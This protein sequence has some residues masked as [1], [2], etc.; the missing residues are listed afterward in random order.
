M[1][2]TKESH[3]FVIEFKYSPAVV[4]EVK[5]LPGRRFDP[6]KKHWIV[7]LH[8]VI[9]VE[10]FA[11]RKRTSIID[12]SRYVIEKINVPPM[13]DLDIQIPINGEMFLYQKQGVA[14]NLLHKRT[15]IGDVPGLGKT[16]QSIA[17][18]LGAEIK[19]DEPFPCL[20]VCPSTLKINWQR[21]WM[22]WSGER[23]VILNDELKNRWPV[24][25]NTGRARVFIVN[26]ESLKKYFVESINRDVDKVTMRQIKFNNNINFFNSIIIDESH[27]TKNSGSLQSKFVKGLSENKKYILAL[28]GTPVV[29]TPADLIPQLSILGRLNEFGGYKVF[30]SKYVDNGSKELLQELSDKLKATCF[31]RR[32]KHEVLKELPS[33]Q[34]SMILCDITTRKEY[35]EAEEDVLEYL[36]KY[37]NA[38]PEQIDAAERGKIMVQI[39]NLKKISA[40][41]KLPSL[42]EYVDEIV[43][44]GEKVVVFAHHHEILDEIISRY[45]HV[46]VAITGAVDL[47]ERQISVDRFQ[48]DD[49]VQVAVCGIK[50]AGVGLTLTAASRVCFVE[51]AWHP[52]DHEQCEDRVHRIGQNEGVV[53]TYF[54]GEYTYDQEIY[55]IISEKREISN[56]ITG[57]VDNVREDVFSSLLQ[58]MIEDNGTSRTHKPRGENEVFP[59]RLF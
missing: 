54:I 47:D 10:E 46:C 50:A 21:E 35:D 4:A 33:K 37:K 28:T 49:S 1:K 9:E 29:N 38:S 53:A 44:A 59:A 48:N 52:A 40:R 22:K 41:G 12:P 11:R 14:Y 30:K 55:R 7:P 31:Y 16:V 18:I 32:E 42:F 25:V 58:F 56:T 6:V 51:L 34:R 27:R 19:G 23:A 13:P 17:T 43:E 26:Y 24:M 39:M 20:V 15:I 36:R 3:G 57:A 8:N 45:K 2:I 5:T